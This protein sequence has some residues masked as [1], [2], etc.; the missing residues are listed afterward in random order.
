MRLD[1]KAEKLQK[2]PGTTASGGTHFVHS[3]LQGFDPK[4]LGH[5][6]LCLLILS[7]TYKAVNALCHITLQPSRK[8]PG[9]LSAL[10]LL[11]Y[12]KH[13]RRGLLCSH[14]TDG[15]KLKSKLTGSTS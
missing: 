3:A 12:V 1:Y 9:Q 7:G 4:Q 10:T 15:C 6:I 11:A 13:T 5:A 2:P 8:T 14:I